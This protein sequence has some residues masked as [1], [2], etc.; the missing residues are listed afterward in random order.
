MPRPPKHY[1]AKVEVVES[2]PDPEPF[3]AELAAKAIL[4]K[5]QQAVMQMM[6]GSNVNRSLQADFESFTKE[7]RSRGE[8]MTQQVEMA[9][10]NED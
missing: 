6:A 2:K 1:M 4:E 7:I 3:D 9:L 5:E 10:S 8:R